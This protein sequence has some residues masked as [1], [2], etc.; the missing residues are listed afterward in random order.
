MHRPEADCRRNRP[1]LTALAARRE[2]VPDRAAVLDHV[3]RCGRCAHELQELAL[4]VI[5]LR[6]LGQ[7]PD[8]AAVSPSAW[9][10]LRDRIERSR[11]AAAELAWHWRTTLAGLAAGTFVV[12]ALVAPTA[13]H[14]GSGVVGAEPAGYSAHELELLNRRVEMTYVAGARTGTLAAATVTTGSQGGI[15]KRYPDGIIPVGKE[16]PPRSSGRPPSVD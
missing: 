6:R 9:P 4:A 12:A 10:R 15:P 11:A 7:L 3:D 16:V 13:L 1:A 8:G 14:V 2:H 5:A